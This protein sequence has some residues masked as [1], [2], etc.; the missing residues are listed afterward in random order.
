MPFFLRT[1]AN[2]LLERYWL[3]SFVNYVCD[4]AEIC[5]ILV[6]KETVQLAHIHTTLQMK[7]IRVAIHDLQMWCAVEIK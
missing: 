3:V 4:H 2:W 1:K 6:I 5:N 7:V